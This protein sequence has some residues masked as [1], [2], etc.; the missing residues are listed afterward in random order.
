MSTEELDRLYSYRKDDKWINSVSEFKSITKVSDSLLAVISPLFKFPDWVKNP[1]KSKSYSKL[2][3]PVKSFAQKEDLN[4]VTSAELQETIGV[5]DFIAERIIKHRKNL[6]GFI[7]DLQLKD[8]I[9]LYENQRNKIL[10]LYTVKT[11]K[12]IERININRASVKELMEVPY[13]D[14]ETALDIKDFIEENNRISNLEELGKIEGFSLE[15]IDRIGLY[16]I[17]N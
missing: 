17:L 12:E 13:F 6:S 7:S 2:K 10:A 3:Y 9:G 1:K 16:L 5:P 15:K 8:I 14:F 4:I 11:K